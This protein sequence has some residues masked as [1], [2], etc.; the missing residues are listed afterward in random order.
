LEAERAEENVLALAGGDGEGGRME[1]QLVRALSCPA[2]VSLENH[3]QPRTITRFASDHP[4]DRAKSG[5]LISMFHCSLGGTIFVYQGQELGMCNVPRDWPTEEY[6]DVETRQFIEG[7][8]EYRK[9]AGDPNPDMKDVLKSL[10]MT[11]RDNG[12]TPMQVRPV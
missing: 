3:D 6:K 9:R 5:K 8:T 10:R 1:L 7:E 4:D 2:N 11:A 12:R